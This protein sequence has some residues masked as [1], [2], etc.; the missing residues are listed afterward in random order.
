MSTNPDPNGLP[1]APSRGCP[2]S[3]AMMERLLEAARK[4]G[5][6]LVYKVFA[7]GDSTTEETPSGIYER[8]ARRRTL[9][10]F[11]ERRP[12]LKALLDC[13]AQERRDRLLS[14]LEDEVE[15]IALGPGDI[16]QDFDD[17]GR[18]KRTRVDRRN[19]LHAL[20]K[21]LASHD[22]DTYAERRKLDAT[23]SG[24]VNH[25]HA[26]LSLGNAPGGYVIDV[27]ALE[28]LEP[29]DR[30]ELMRILAK[31]EEVRLERREP[32]ALPPGEQA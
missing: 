1:L 19:K 20:L 23:V 27:A 25:A 21:L 12:D 3:A 13:A 22:P 2:V 11:L 17:K 24:Q 32:S 29:E 15:K 28:A 4:G 16:T 9:A 6:S 14:E 8:P 7:E 5:W 31:V 30:A 18:L 26:H 10:N